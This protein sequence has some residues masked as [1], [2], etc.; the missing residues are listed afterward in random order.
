[1]FKLE[2]VLS[3]LC[4]IAAV[5]GMLKTAYLVPK[6]GARSSVG[7]CQ[8]NGSAIQAG[9]G[10]VGTCWNMRERVRF[11]PDSCIPQ[12]S[13]TDLCLVSLC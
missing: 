4:D 11:R 5:S 7:L 13:P 10:R 2:R 12:P 9:D 3:A 1:M 6:H 8:G